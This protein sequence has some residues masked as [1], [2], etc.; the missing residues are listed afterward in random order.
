MPHLDISG[1]HRHG[2][3][4]IQPST[5]GRHRPVPSS[6]P[7][8]VGQQSVCASGGPGMS[9]SMTDDPDYK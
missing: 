1:K 8:C 4:G 5:N 9:I 7:A 2:Q 3:R 6:L